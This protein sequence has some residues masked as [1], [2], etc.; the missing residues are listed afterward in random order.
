MAVLQQVT[1]VLIYPFA[2]DQEIGLVKERGVLNDLATVSRYKDSQVLELEPA[3]KG[4]ALVRK[5][6]KLF[7]IH[8]V[9]SLWTSLGR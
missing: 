5:I 4:N 1:N 7:D 2:F 3:R 8:T 6:T 9:P